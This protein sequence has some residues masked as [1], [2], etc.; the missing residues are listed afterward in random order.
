MALAL[1]SSG[2]SN[3]KFEYT[4]AE[5]NLAHICVSVAL[6]FAEF[7]VPKPKLDPLVEAKLEEI[8]GGHDGVDTLVRA[9]YRGF[10][11]DLCGSGK[12]FRSSS[13]FPKER[14]PTSVQLLMRT[15]MERAGRKD[16]V[17]QVFA[18]YGAKAS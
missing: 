10:I 6:I 8:K 5:K 9:L 11:K 17:D 7:N 12:E 15:G 18:R 14:D 13:D 1:K 4:E 2:G 3:G 16:I